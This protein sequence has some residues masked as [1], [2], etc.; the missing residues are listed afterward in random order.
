M[1]DLSIRFDFADN[2]PITPA[3]DPPPLPG[4]Y[5]SLDTQI[6]T[7]CTSRASYS[8]GTTGSILQN[9]SIDDIIVNDTTIEI[10]ATA[11]SGSS[12]V[13]A[14]GT[15]DDGSAISFPTLN[16]SSNSGG[17]GDYVAAVVAFSNSTGISGDLVVGAP[18]SFTQDSTPSGHSGN[19]AATYDNT[20]TGGSS[21]FAPGGT[22]ESSNYPSGSVIA[23][24]IAFRDVFSD[25]TI[26]PTDGGVIVGGKATVDPYGG[27]VA[28]GSA[29]ANPYVPLGGAKINGEAQV[30]PVAGGV[31]LGGK[32]FGVP[33]SNN[34]I[35]QLTSTNSYDTVFGTPYTGFDLHSNLNDGLLYD[36]PNYLTT[37]TSTY[38]TIN[39]GYNWLDN[40]VDFTFDKT[41]ILE[42]DEIA[43]ITYRLIGERDG[44]YSSY[45]SISNI[46]FIINNDYTCFTSATGGVSLQAET[47]TTDI[48]ALYD[49]GYTTKDFIDSALIRFSAGFSLQANAGQYITYNYYMEFVTTIVPQ[50]GGSIV[51]GSATEEAISFLGGGGSLVSGSASISI[52]NTPSVSSGVLVG[53]F[54]RISINV[55]IDSYGVL[56]NGTSLIGIL[57]NSTGGGVLSGVSTV[58]GPVV[59]EGSGG[60]LVGGRSRVEIEPKIFNPSVLVG[61]ESFNGRTLTEIPDGG[62]NLNG[63]AIVS[64]EPAISGGVFFG[65]LTIV[66]GPVVEEGSGGITILPEIELYTV[67][68]RETSSGI[69]IPELSLYID[70]VKY[71]PPLPSDIE[72]F[73]SGG[74]TNSDP[75][76]SLGGVVSTVHAESDLFEDFRPEY[77][78]TGLTEYRCLYLFNRLNVP[79]VNVKIWLEKYSSSSTGIVFG[80]DES[81]DIQEISMSF[82]S[83]V[84][85]ATFDFNGNDIVVNGSP[86]LDV[87]AQNLQDSLRNNTDLSE[88]EVSGRTED[89]GFIFSVIFTGADGSRNQSFI[90]L[91]DNN[92]A[93]SPEITI[94]KVQEGSPINA[95]AEETADNIT[96]PS[97]PIFKEITESSPIS[98]ALGVDEGFPLW[99][100]RVV[101]ANPDP[102]END[103][104]SIKMITTPIDFV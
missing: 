9:A 76:K 72:F 11:G 30:G 45:G 53:G 26:E 92:L 86:D 37:G 50:G 48:S 91:K 61:G 93:G 43:S 18:T 75:T 70:V 7:Y 65:S 57:S 58:S 41:P 60:I 78:S 3:T 77:A 31:K 36:D 88:V 100:K 80:V 20:I 99:I 101:E 68:S 34:F 5:T 73:L 23:Y 62:V 59:N 84:G 66:S 8:G 25:V 35:S 81:D 4:G 56:A 79:L 46:C 24:A 22:A 10:Q 97:N 102:V 69:K 85:T 83:G 74:L 103:R 38:I 13:I 82:L 1:S 67:G 29:V 87:F 6:T 32:A 28:G 71:F 39:N 51:G 104:F 33:T 52:G 40:H 90:A 96:A 44:A 21:S 14:V 55:L 63:R 16:L 94:Q 95:I 19:Y 89:S 47:S 15:S 54:I 42:E 98:L 17:F 12:I 27:V 64:I 2:D 49:L